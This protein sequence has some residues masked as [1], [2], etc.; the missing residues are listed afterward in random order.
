MDNIII[1]IINFILLILVR[2]ALNIEY[3]NPL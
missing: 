3:I 2:N 1:N